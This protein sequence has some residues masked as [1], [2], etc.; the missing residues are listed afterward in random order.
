MGRSFIQTCNS[1]RTAF[2]VDYTLVHVCVHPPKAKAPEAT[3]CRAFCSDRMYFSEH[4]RGFMPRL[5]PVLEFRHSVVEDHS[6]ETGA[7]RV[8]P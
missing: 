2:I 3:S 6:S 8:R 1:E 4:E 7:K 5:L